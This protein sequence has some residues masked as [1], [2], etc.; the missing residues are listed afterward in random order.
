MSCQFCKFAVY[1]PGAFW[2]TLVCE[3]E[4]G[5]EG[6][7]QQ[8][9]FTGACENFTSHQSARLG[10]C[11]NVRYIPLTQ[12]KVAIVDKE[13]YPALIRY[14][15]HAVKSS[16][17]FYVRSR[18]NNRSMLMHRFIMN[19]PEE[20]FVDHIDH[21]GLNNRKSNLRICTKEQNARNRQPN[22]R[23]KGKYKGVHFDK[24]RKKFKAYIK[25]QDR[26]LSI[27][28]YKEEINAAKA[29]DKKAKQ[30]FKEYAYLNFPKK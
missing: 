30:L 23:K 24:A 21:N 13:D 26:S 22:K 29:Y 12:G 19:P 17:T 10:G 25:C 18:V 1:A 14:K 7:W 3:N 16:Q 27:G 8:I 4:S 2:P 28:Y 20:M 6:L 5:S 9:D 11:S 15:W